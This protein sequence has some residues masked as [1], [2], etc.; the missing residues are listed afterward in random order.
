MKKPSKLRHKVLL[1]LRF[2][3]A[4]TVIVYLDLGGGVN[5]AITGIVDGDTSH[6]YDGLLY[7]V[8]LANG[9]LGD[10]ADVFAFGQLDGEFLAFIVLAT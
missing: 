9:L 10:Y 7:G 1:V 2:F 8:Y 4:V 6:F 3:R 5:D